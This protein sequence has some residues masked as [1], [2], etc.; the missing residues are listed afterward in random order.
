QVAAMELDVAF[1]PAG[2]PVDVAVVI[3]VLR[4]TTTAATLLERGMQTL[5]IVAETGAALALAERTGALLFGERHGVAFPGFHGGNSP[6][7]HQGRDYGGQSAILCT[8]NGSRAVEAVAGARAVLLGSIVNARAVARL[9]LSLATERITLVCAGTDGVVS[10][11]DVLGAGC[12]ATEVLAARDD[13]LATDSAR[14]ALELAAAPA[15]VEATLAKA[16][17]ADALLAI[18]FAEDVTLAGRRSSSAWVP[19]MV[20]RGPAVFESVHM[21]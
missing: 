3:D 2:D 5:T 17:H 21:G 15:G 10:L 14:I 12:I 16:R 9:A 7:E 20:T 18:G 19:R 6:V 4:M 13:V 1:L 8:T 11:D